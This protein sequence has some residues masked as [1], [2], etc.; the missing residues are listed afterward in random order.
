MSEVE[1]KVEEQNWSK[2]KI[3]EIL[4][5]MGKLSEIDLQL[6]L[7]KGTLRQEPLG[8]VLLTEN[9]VTELDLASALA[10]QASL[11]FRDLAN[12]RLDKKILKFVPERVAKKYM[13]LP[14]EEKKGKLTI[15][16]DDPTR[17][18]EL[19]FVRQLVGGEVTFVV[20][21]ASQ[22]RRFL[23][24][25]Y[26]DENSATEAIAKKLQRVNQAERLQQ[27]AL[28]KTDKKPEKQAAPRDALSI[29]SLVSEIIDEAM[30]RK[31]SDIHIE[32]MEDNIV[33]R[34]RVFGTLQ[35]ASTIPYDL[36]NIL[37]TRLKIVANLDIAEKR[38]P[39]DG[40]FRHYWGA[41][42]IDLRL[43]TLPLVRGEKC[44]M[45]ILD[46]SALKAKLDLL[47]MPGTM[48]ADIKTMSTK[49]Y[50]IIFVTGPTGSGKTTTV[51]SVL[52]LL[53]KKLKNITTIEDPVE[54]QVDG[55]NQVQINNAA[56]ITFAAALKSILR[57]DP[58]VVMVGEIRDK[59]TADIAIR[60][61]LTGHLV[62]STLHTNDSVAAIYRLMDMGID[63]FLVAAAI[64]GIIAQRLVKRLCLHCKTTGPVDPD[65]RRW[66]GEHLIPEGTIVGKKVGCPKCFNSGYSGREAVFELLNPNEAVRRAISDGKTDQ[67]IALVLKE[68]A[69]FKRMRENSLEKILNHITTVE[70]VIEQTN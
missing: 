4:V 41:R 16:I 35:T 69:G 66:Y 21:P 9:M 36:Y 63:A 22:L 27:E 2:M 40:S 39:Q 14:L 7:K 45:R 37:V 18:I 29:E 26:L 30:E 60:A 53:D 50:G 25:A 48:A 6:A 24:K 67:E 11:E 23:D 42:A 68:T 65:E 1:E 47:G 64:V 33:V 13:A 3:G 56:G 20:V 32:P 62:I 49:P 43:S 58:D 54:Y 12:V 15:A 55:I 28:D 38:K 8:T 17:F 5:G 57:Q 31:A 19:N 44:V 70:E 10:K 52:N 46:K 34:Y 61:A 51:Y 59:E